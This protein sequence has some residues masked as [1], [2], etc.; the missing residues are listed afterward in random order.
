MITFFVTFKMESPLRNQYARITAPNV[1][2][3]CF[4]A[5]N[6]WGR[7]LLAVYPPAS[8][9]DYLGHT[10]ALKLNLKELVWEQ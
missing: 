5:Q 7:D 3:A 1:T 6:I 8:W 9:T 4:L 10:V 2:E